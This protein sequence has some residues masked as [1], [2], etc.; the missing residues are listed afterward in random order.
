[1]QQITRVLVTAQMKKNKTWNE[2]FSG[3]RDANI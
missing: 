2:R 3:D 1:M